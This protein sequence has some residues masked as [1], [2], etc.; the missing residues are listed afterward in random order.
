MKRLLLVVLIL[1]FVVR[2]YKISSPLADW[3]SFRQ[4]DTASVTREYLKHGI[5]LLRPKYHDLS[6]IQSGKENPRGYRMVEFPVLNGITAGAI[7]VLGQQSQEVLIGRLV[8]VLF[9]LVALVS[10]YGVGSALSSKRVGLVAAA[11]FAV[12]PYSVYYSRAIL[13]D[14]P[15]VAMTM[16]SLWFYLVAL[17]KKR[18]IPYAVALLSFTAALFMKPYAVFFIPLF[19]A[20]KW[21]KEGLKGMS[22]PKLYLLPAL[23]VIPLYFWRQ[24]ILQFPEG[25]PAS[26]W[27]F[28]KENIRF[29]GAFF[30]WLFEVRISTLIFGIGLVVPFVLGLLKKGKDQVVYLVWGALMLAYLWIFA[31]GNVQHDYY[32]VVLLPFL[33]LTTARGIEFL[34]ELPPKLIGRWTAV[35]AVGA[36]VAF[37]LFVSWYTVRGYYQINHFEIIQA[38]QAVD[39]LL[40]KDAKVI[41]PY[42]GDTA[43]LFQTNR[44]GWP[45]GF[46]I[47]ERIGN[48]AQFYVSVNFDDEANELMKKYTIV[49][50]TDKFVIIDLQKPA[51]K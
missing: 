43:F 24:W 38:G 14:M 36:L 33:F 3:H 26:D 23:S 42:M 7:Q 8:V 2:L 25:I 47:D 11:L 40:P 48:G 50:K 5:D 10:I 13:P 37:S 31:G 49:E 9:S 1:A 20:F 6:N 35:V 16:V 17:E 12:M 21:H 22:D 39:R 15:F 34:F 41:A 45:L 28:N 29:S 46:W 30:H 44:T 19:F 18:L 4:A 27:L 32:Q 51:T